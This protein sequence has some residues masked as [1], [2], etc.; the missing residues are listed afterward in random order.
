MEGLPFFKAIIDCS[1]A[2]L[3]W[4]AAHTQP[5]PDFRYPVNAFA[6]E[7]AKRRTES[8]YPWMDKGYVAPQRRRR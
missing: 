7:G 3:K 6:G 8:V 1:S 5:E 4:R 2:H